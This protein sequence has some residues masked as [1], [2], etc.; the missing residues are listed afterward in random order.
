MA[1]IPLTG[2]SGLS[3]SMV[4]SNAAR[5]QQS[6]LSNGMALLNAHSASAQQQRTV[7]TPP[8][9]PKTNWSTGST[10]S[11]GGPSGGSSGGYSGGSSGSA[12]SAAAA[13]AARAAAEKTAR[14]N[15]LNEATNTQVNALKKML[16]STFGQARMCERNENI[17]FWG[18]KPP[19]IAG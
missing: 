1:M 4:L 8:S 3:K 17:A 11:Y 13:A 10:R 12:Y 16:D 5:Q 6:P 9:A 19:W 14:E 7:Y 18:Q 15:K 2:G